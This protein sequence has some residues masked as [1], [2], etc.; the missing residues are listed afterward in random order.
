MHLLNVKVDD[1]TRSLIEAAVALSGFPTRSEWMREALIAGAN[2]EIA[3]AQRRSVGQHARLGMRWGRG[4]THPPTAIWIG[5]VE[6]VC[7]LCGTVVRSR[8]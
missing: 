4:C 1:D 6:D 8:L 2:R 5:I 7:T 3:E